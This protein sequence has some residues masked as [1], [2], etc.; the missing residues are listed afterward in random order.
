[1]SSRGRAY[2]RQARQKARVRTGKY[3]GRWGFLDDLSET[4]RQ[5]KVSTM[6]TTRRR[7]SCSMCSSHKWDKRKS[8]LQAEACLHDNKV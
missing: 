6:S 5:A 3:L 2:R 1:M 8:D 7:C 4:E